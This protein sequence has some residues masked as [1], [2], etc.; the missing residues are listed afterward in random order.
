MSEPVECSA[1]VD[2]SEHVWG[3]LVIEPGT[4]AVIDVA[5]L[6]C[7][8]HRSALGAPGPAA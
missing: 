6:F 7:G 1:I 3:S 8:I 2:I 5:C 4:L